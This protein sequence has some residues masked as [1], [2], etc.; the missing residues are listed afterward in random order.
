M[1][2]A[3][4]RH[5]NLD[6]ADLRGAVLRGAKLENATMRQANLEGADLREAI[7]TY[8][9]ANGVNFTGV[10]F[11]GIEFYMAD[12]LETTGM[13]EEVRAHALR[14]RCEFGE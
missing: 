2:G 12:L 6:G 14:M 3:D 5:A 9:V 13:P 10:Q 7:F 4:L 11:D 1:A 8:C